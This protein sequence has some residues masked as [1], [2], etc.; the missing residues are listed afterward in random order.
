MRN[1]DL[2]QQTLDT[3]P[4]GRLTPQATSRVRADPTTAGPADIVTTWVCTRRRKTLVPQPDL[5]RDRP[6]KLWTLDDVPGNTFV[7][8][9]VSRNESVDEERDAHIADYACRQ[10]HHSSTAP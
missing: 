7:I 10:Q 4:F 3:R 9:N 8:P 6:R 2:T 1:K 5:E